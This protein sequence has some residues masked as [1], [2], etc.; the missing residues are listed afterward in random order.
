MYHGTKLLPCPRCGGEGRLY[1][2]FEKGELQVGGETFVVPK[3]RDAYVACRDCERRTAS[4]QQ[5][6]IAIDMWN[7]QAKES[8]YE[9]F[10]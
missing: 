5:D 9:S 3:F 8:D 7:E 4:C 2:E 6:W 10:Y 1:H